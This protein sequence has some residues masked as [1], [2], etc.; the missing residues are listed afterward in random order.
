MRGRRAAGGQIVLRRCQSPAE[1]EIWAAAFR[2]VLTSLDIAAWWRVRIDPA[3][4]DTLLVAVDYQPLT[5]PPRARSPFR[6]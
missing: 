5:P 3:D 4:A 2:A 1:A 6:R